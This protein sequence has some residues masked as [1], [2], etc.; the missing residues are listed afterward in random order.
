MI[1]D[2]VVVLYQPTADNISH[3]ADYAPLINRLYVIDNSDTTSE[4]LQ[5]NINVLS[6]FKN[7]S[8]I[9]MGTNQG[10]A[11]A[12]R[13]GTEKAIMDEADFCLTMDQDSIFP[14]DKMSDIIKYL[15]RSDINDYG[16]IAL[17]ANYGTAEEGLIQINAVISSGNFINLRNYRKIKGF[18]DELFIDSVDFD[19]CNQFSKAEKKIAYIGEIGLG[20]QIGNPKYK[21]FFGKRCVVTNH[22][23]IRCYYRFRN[24]YFLYHEDKAFYKEIYKADKRQIFKIIFFEKNKIAK[25]K[26][27][28]LGIKHAKQHKL[29]KLEI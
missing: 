24:N 25:L 27:I 15:S 21:K 20:H 19:L 17:N 13:I 22:S 8:I 11:H 4:E 9:S 26:M 28:R 18:R 23:P 29:G 16:I 2:G 1:I 10:I 7:V 14:T 12:L 5:N 3:I 6:R